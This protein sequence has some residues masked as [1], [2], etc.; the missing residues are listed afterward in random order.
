[1]SDLDTSI[2]DNVELTPSTCKIFILEVYLIDD[3]EL[4]SIL[5]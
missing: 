2:I 1:M 3:A 4:E 5:E